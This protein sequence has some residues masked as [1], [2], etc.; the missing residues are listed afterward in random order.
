MIQFREYEVCAK[1]KIS[2]DER[3]CDPGAES[4]YDSDDEDLMDDVLALPEGVSP[5]DC[6][7]QDCTPYR[8]VAKGLQVRLDP[9]DQG[10]AY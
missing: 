6:L 4:A 7:T 1:G 10:G 8:L 5:E 2:N 3:P 9:A